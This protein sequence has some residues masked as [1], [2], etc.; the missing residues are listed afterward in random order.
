MREPFNWEA[1]NSFVEALTN[2]RRAIGELR[3][4]PG[5]EED[6]N[7]VVDLI[8]T[9][10]DVFFDE[11]R[12]HANAGGIAPHE[13]AFV[14][15]VKHAGALLSEAIKNPSYTGTGAVMLRKR[16]AR[17]VIHMLGYEY[18]SYRRS[19]NE[20]AEGADEATMDFCEGW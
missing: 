5:L 20:A 11:I 14:R 1:Q 16:R 13:A 7:A 12:P 3:D 15:A 6:C 8:D 4:T 17:D 2:C 18:A 9:A 19:C 10:S